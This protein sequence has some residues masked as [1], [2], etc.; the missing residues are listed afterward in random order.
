MEKT[1]T[2]SEKLFIGLGAISCISGIIL[3][4]EHNLVIGIAGSIVGL[5]LVYENLQKLKAKNKE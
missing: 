4:I 1:N 2:K 5:W 3:A